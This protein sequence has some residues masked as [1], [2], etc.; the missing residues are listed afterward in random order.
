MFFAFFQKKLPHFNPLSTEQKALCIPKYTRQSTIRTHSN[1]QVPLFQLHTSEDLQKIPRARLKEPGH[2]LAKPK[3]AKSPAQTQNRPR[4]KSCQLP[5]YSQPG[6]AAT[7]HLIAGGQLFCRVRGQARGSPERRGV[8]WVVC[9]TRRCVS[10]E[11]W[12]TPGPTVEI[13]VHTL[14]LPREPAR[15]LSSRVWAVPALCM[16]EAEREACA[17]YGGIPRGCMY[18]GLLWSC[19]LFVFFRQVFFYYTSFRDVGIV[20]C[21]DEFHFGKDYFLHFL[22][23]ALIF[24]ASNFNEESL[25][26]ELAISRLHDRG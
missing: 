19:N 24:F 23:D 1:Q 16:R 11:R 14:L 9:I 2:Q 13:Y 25:W 10:T 6:R 8:E 4:K 7:S 12:T 26:L 15:G 5:Q 18:A 17:L 3:Q 21:T 22:M 20:Y